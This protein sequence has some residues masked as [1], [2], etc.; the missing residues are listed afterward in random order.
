MAEMVSV[1]VTGLKELERSLFAMS[2]KVRTKAIRS[3]L[4]GGS[5]IVKKEAIA[6]VPVKTGTLKKAIYVK[7]MSK[8][9]P[10]REAYIVGVRHGKKLRKAGMDAFYWSFIEFGHKD[11][12]GKAVSPQPFIVPAFENKKMSALDRIKVVLQRKIAQYAREKA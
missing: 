1:Q 4:A 10:F 7:R 9:N 8:P 2:S 5:Q 6:K 3:A 11:R 12:A